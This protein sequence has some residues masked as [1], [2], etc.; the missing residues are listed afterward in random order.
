MNHFELKIE[1]RDG[2]GNRGNYKIN[3]QFH[4]KYRVLILVLKTLFG[5]K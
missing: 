5:K 1:L 2:Y 4:G 3:M